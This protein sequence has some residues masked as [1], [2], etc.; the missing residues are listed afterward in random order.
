MIFLLS[1][2]TLWLIII[3]EPV[4]F[5]RIGSVS[6]KKGACC[7]SFSDAAQAHMALLNIV[8]HEPEIPQNTGNIARTCAA[9]GSALH[10]IKPMGSNAPGLITGTSSILRITKTLRTS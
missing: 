2:A 9:T 6:Q 8:L 5:L 1:R 3:A 10:I 7:I 4:V